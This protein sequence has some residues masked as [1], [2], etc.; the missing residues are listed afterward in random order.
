[1]S[2]LEVVAADDPR[3]CRLCRVYRP[4]DDPKLPERDLAPVCGRDRRR[5]D[6][7]LAALPGLHERLRNPDLSTGDERAMF[8][9]AWDRQGRRAWSTMPAAAVSGRT[10]QPAVSGS[11][12]RREPANLNTVDL[13]A[14]VRGTNLTDQGRQH[15]E[16]HIGRIS[17]AT[18]L[19]G[20]VQTWRDD[21]LFS[22]QHRPPARVDEL[23]RWLRDRVEQA[24]SRLDPEVIVDFASEIRSVRGALHAALG[25]TKA[26]PDVKVGVRCPQCDDVSTLEQKPGEDWV[27]CTSCGELVSPT[28]YTRLAKGWG[29]YE[30]DHRTPEEIEGLMRR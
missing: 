6:L 11:P 27:E 12:Q 26:E 7:D 25:E 14:H 28:D 23:A 21:V 1:M 4:D 29:D 24:C 17:V 13:T 8:T 10:N 18:L 9:I 2:N 16:D 20:W 15:P 19:D 22:G 5:L 3:A 30:R